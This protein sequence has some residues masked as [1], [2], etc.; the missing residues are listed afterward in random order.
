MSPKIM[1]KIA[2][3]LFLFPILSFGQD[4]I[5]VN[6]NQR[7][8]ALSV[9]KSIIENDCETY[10][11]SINDS[12]VLYFSVNDTI[13]AKDGIKDKL[14][15]LCQISIKNDTLDYNYYL[16]NFHLHFFDAKTLSNELKRSSNDES[17]SLGTLRY[18]KIMNDDIF[19]NGS[20]HKSE[21]RL[22][23]I[24]DDAFKFLIRRVNDEYKIILL[25][26]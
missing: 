21:D 8:F 11:N 2:V 19:F 14:K 6:K 13:V 3:I 12:V 25:T 15:M 5:Q 22:D 1:N 26:N 20:Y 7:E 4:T 23:F 17:S 18:Y 16:N 9:V 10:Y 24:I